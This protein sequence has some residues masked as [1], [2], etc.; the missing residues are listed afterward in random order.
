MTRRVK[1][2]KSF[3]AP[4]AENFLKKLSSTNDRFRRKMLRY[5]LW[6]V[7]L[8]VVYSFMSGTYGIPRI[9]RLKLEKEALISENREFVAI[10]VD[11]ERTRGM[12]KND[13]DYIENIARTKY[14]MAYPN[15]TIYRYSGR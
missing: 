5:G 4:L 9:V 11:A 10:I 3:L 7:A 15:E 8:L 12:L 6:I 2:S 14:F 13:R 1:Q